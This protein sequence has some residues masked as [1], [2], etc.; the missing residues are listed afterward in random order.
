MFNSPGIPFVRHVSIIDSCG[1]GEKYYTPVSENPVQEHLACVIV[2][3]QFDRLQFA[4]L[5]ESEEKRNQ[6]FLI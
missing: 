1:P 5:C 6:I 2:P 3:F 4:D